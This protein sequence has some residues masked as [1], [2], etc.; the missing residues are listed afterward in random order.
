M[1]ERDQLP[2]G[3]VATE[4][5]ALSPKGRLHAVIPAG[6]ELADMEYVEAIH[7]WVAE[8]IKAMTDETNE[9]ITETE[10]TSDPGTETPE[11]D[12]A[13]EDDPSIGHE[14]VEEGK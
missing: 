11:P 2:P 13:S 7:D 1:D 10:P 9:P 5:G 6:Y 12:E 8:Y 4:L 3:W 14:P